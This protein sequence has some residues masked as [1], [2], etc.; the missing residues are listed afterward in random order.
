[1]VTYGQLYRR[2]RTALEPEE[3]SR[4][5]FTARELLSFVSGHTPAALMGMQTIYAS[6]DTARRYLELA[7]RVRG[8]EP[9]A[10]ILGRWSF[11]GLDLTVTPDVLIPRD[12]TMAVVDLALEV[13]RNLPEIP[14]ILDLCTG[15]GCI[16][17]ALASQI[18]TARVTLADLSAK[19][20][21]IAKKNTVDLHLTGRVSCIQADAMEP[22]NRFLGQFDLLISNP[23]YVTGPEMETLPHSVR[24]FEPH[25]ALYGGK[26]GLDF[27]HAIAVNYKTAIRPG[28][29]LAMEFGMGQEDAVSWI[30]E[31]EDYEIIRLREDTGGITRAIL[32]MKKERNDEDGE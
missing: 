14:R 13:R 17:L 19:A 12:D 18:R 22:A 32:A 9:L 15:S 28:G 10:Y 4:A 7:E 2:V 16:G 6:E 27:Y 24:D 20:L 26:D 23:P 8:G 5:A 30:L 21:K 31:A 3:G 1:M 29:Y 25:M 11:Y